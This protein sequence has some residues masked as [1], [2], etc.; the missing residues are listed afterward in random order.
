MDTQDASLTFNEKSVLELL[1]THVQSRKDAIDVL[2][3]KAQ[4]NFTVANILAAILA[5]FNLD[6]LSNANPDTVEQ[7]RL[8]LLGLM[9]IFYICIAT[10]STYAMFV[11][12]RLSHPMEPC[13]DVVKEWSECT[14]AHHKKILSDSYLHIYNDLEE[15]NDS[16]AGAVRAAQLLILFAI[17][18]FL[19]MGYMYAAT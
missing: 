17:A 10:L 12:P 9:G 3:K 14:L 1:K 19:L 7:L 4:Y 6:S 18:L 2:Q 5:G 11:R 8:N 16:L 13:S 15:M